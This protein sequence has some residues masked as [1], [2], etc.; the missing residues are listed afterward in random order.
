MK[1]QC[2]ECV[3]GNQNCIYRIKALCQ[4]EWFYPSKEAMAKEKHSKQTTQY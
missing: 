2:S 3:M 4:C 1:E